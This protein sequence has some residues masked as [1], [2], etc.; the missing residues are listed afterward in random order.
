MS[1]TETIHFSVSAA[2]PVP[3]PTTLGLLAMGCC[4]LLGVYLRRRYRN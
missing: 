2:S 3:E 1:D 4:G